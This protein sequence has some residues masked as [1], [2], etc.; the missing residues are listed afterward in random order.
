MPS[1]NFVVSISGKAFS[2]ESQVAILN[3]SGNAQVVFGLNEKNLW[4]FP[5]CKKSKEEIVAALNAAPGLFDISV[6]PMD[7]PLSEEQVAMIRQMVTGFELDI[8]Q[9]SDEELS[10]Y[11]NSLSEGKPTHFL[12]VGPDAR[13]VPGA[14]LLVCKPIE[15]HPDY[16]PKWLEEIYNRHTRTLDR[17]YTVDD[18]DIIREVY[19][20]TV[21]EDESPDDNDYRGVADNEETS[22]A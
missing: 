5:K 19:I 1:N 20:E 2:K 9:V 6:L 22:T 18:I 16:S 11:L 4:I 7:N 8:S 3:L 13:K 14:M 12:D 21:E 10:A 15:E 17:K